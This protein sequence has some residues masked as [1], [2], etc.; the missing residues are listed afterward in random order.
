MCQDIQTEEEAGPGHVHLED[1]GLD[2]GRG[3]ATGPGHRRETNGGDHTSVGRPN[4]GLLNEGRPNESRPNKGRS[5]GGRLNEETDQ[6]HSRE[7]PDKRVQ[8]M[9]G[10]LTQ[11][12]VITSD[13][14]HA[15]LSSCDEVLASIDVLSHDMS[16]R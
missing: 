10:W 4:E 7:D 1:L 2:L 11:D 16:L 8:E 13:I 15:S 5:K 9:K 6:D 14:G 3:N 12:Q